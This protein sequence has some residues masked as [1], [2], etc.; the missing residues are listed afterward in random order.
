MEVLKMKANY[1]FSNSVKNPY[2]KKLKKQISI[3]VN[4]DTIDYF[5]KLSA[6]T[7]I[8]Y[9]KL[10]NLYLAECVKQHIKPSLE[11]QKLPKMG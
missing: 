10:M 11:W 6:E 2:L 9:Q 3:R 7:S 1:D 8:P 5:K 4:L